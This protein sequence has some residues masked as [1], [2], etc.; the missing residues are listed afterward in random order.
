ML[1]TYFLLLCAY[2][3]KIYNLRS[4]PAALL[5]H[6]K[7]LRCQVCCPSNQCCIQKRFARQ[8]KIYSSGLMLDNFRESFKTLVAFS[9]W[10]LLQLLF[11]CSALGPGTYH[12]L[13]LG[14]VLLAASLNTVIACRSDLYPQKR[15]KPVRPSRCPNARVFR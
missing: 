10:K 8:P 11:E 4:R 1:S 13:R 5:N 7:L 3:Q 15:L 9:F 14:G 6:L 12:C 2:A